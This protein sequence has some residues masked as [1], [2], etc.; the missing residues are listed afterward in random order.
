MVNKG[1][2]GAAVG[3]ASILAAVA[4]M[5]MS[6]FFPGPTSPSEATPQEMKEVIL[7]LTNIQVQKIDAENV[8]IEVVFDVFNP[9]RRTLVLEEIEYNLI[10][11]GIR[12]AQS[13]IGERLEG[14]V[15]GT[16]VYYVVPDLPLTLKDTIQLRKTELFSPIWN[17]L[18]NDNVDWRV[19]GSFF[20]TD[21]IGPGGENMFDFNL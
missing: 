16:G 8:K 19:S 4:F 11:N 7:S 21:P 20:I 5:A 2:A 18:Q 6:G 3:G 17:D 14:L 9:N 12:L 1:L 15:T 10:A 13:D